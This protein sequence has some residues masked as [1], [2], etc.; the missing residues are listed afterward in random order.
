M[1]DSL[2]SK[3]LVIYFLYGTNLGRYVRVLFEPEGSLFKLA[4]TRGFH[5]LGALR[6]S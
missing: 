5:K 4:K 2:S 1:M 3:S 6:T